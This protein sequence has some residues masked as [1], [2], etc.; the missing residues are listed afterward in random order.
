MITANKPGKVRLGT[1]GHVAGRGSSRGRDRRN[2]GPG[3]QHHEGLLE[4]ADASAEVIDADGW[5]HTG[6]VGEF[7][8]DGYLRITDRIKNLL[9]TAGGKNIAPQPLENQ[10][11]MSPYIAQ[12]VML[13]DRRLPHHAAGADL[14][15]LAPWAQA[16]GIGTSTPRRGCRPA[17]QA[18]LESEAL[19]RL[20]GFGSLRDAQ[21]GVHHVA[22]EFTIESGH[23][24]AH[25]EGE[26]QDRGG[27]L[28]ATIEDITYAAGVEA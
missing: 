28:L 12:V 15:N 4:Q 19:S 10:A 20:D 26:A 21:E 8:A 6:D 25:H 23:A 18:V 16:Q 24:H 22:E 7:D 13:G 14:K 17:R 1:V 11:A 2:P 9:V 27:A 5:F 3:P